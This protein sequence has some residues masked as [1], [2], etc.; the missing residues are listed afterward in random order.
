M[1]HEAR[2]I[3]C[4]VEQSNQ[5]RSGNFRKLRSFTCSPP[6]VLGCSINL[7]LPWP[8]YGHLEGP[9]LFVYLAAPTTSSA[10]PAIPLSSLWTE[11]KMSSV[12]FPAH[13]I[14]SSKVV[15]VSMDMALRTIQDFS[16]MIRLDPRV[17]GLEASANDPKL[18]IVKIRKDLLGVSYDTSE[19]M[20]F[21]MVVDGCDMTWSGGLGTSFSA[22]WRAK[23]VEGKTEVTE[24]S[25]V[26]VGPSTQASPRQEYSR[27]PRHFAYDYLLLPATCASRTTACWMRWLPS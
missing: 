11:A 3:D 24:T 23:F 26:K 5:G 2:G 22:S 8:T 19:S 18:Y 27:F 15:D 17:L 10:L 13:T 16:Q 7:G 14:T 12:L 20:K 4:L 6:A 25:T 21:V 1:L 9:L